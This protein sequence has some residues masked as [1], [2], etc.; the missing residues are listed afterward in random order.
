MKVFQKITF[1]AKE[2]ILTHLILKKFSAVTTN[3]PLLAQFKIIFKAIGSI[4][5]TGRYHQNESE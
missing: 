1:S 2:Q 5:G 3:P 4:P